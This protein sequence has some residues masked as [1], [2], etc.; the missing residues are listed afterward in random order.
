MAPMD[1]R[2]DL[3]IVIVGNVQKK[4]SSKLFTLGSTVMA[5]NMQI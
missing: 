3:K 4:I 1:K 5:K 2:P